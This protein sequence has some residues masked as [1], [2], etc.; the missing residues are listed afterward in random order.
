MS[1]LSTCRTFCVSLPSVKTVAYHTLG[2]K[3]NF[4]E[5]SAIARQLSEA[6]FI[7]KD[8]ESAAGIYIINTCSVTE[9]ADRECRKLIRDA[10]KRNPAGLIVVTGCY[11][12]LK[13][14]DISRIPGVDIVLGAGEKFNIVSYLADISK[15]TQTEVHSCETSALQ[16]FVPSFSSGDRTRSFLK[17]QDGCDYPCTYCTIPMARGKSRSGSVSGIREQ[18]ASIASKGV[19]EIVLT[20]VNIGD[21]RNGNETFLDLIRVLDE[22]EGIDRFRISSIEPNLLTEEI[23]RFVAGSRRFAPHFHLPLQSGSDH[24]LGLMKRRYRS[25]LYRDR[26]DLIRKHIPHCA[27]GVD[28]I[29]GFPGETEKEFIE[30]YEFLRTSDVSYLH[31]FTY[32]ERD[33]T[34]ALH[35]GHPVDPRERKKRNRTLQ[36]LSDKKR[37][38]FRQRFE[39]TPRPV[40]FEAGDP[41]GM[42]H[43]YTDNYLKV[44]MPYRSDLVRKTHN[45]LIQPETLPEPEIIH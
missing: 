26:L 10:L 36:I 3:L 44:V 17:I 14:E 11:A 16:D 45:V 30:T 37:R 28:V 32:S 12:Q 20:G 23:I 43:G 1:T 35:L 34:E 24:I 13:P 27:I 41:N 19:R 2:C 21:F 31:V 25:T 38:I 18:A 39:D 9:N 29:V 5:T 22:V 15:R 33:N 7:R 8:F 6:G 42:M 4:S 40:L